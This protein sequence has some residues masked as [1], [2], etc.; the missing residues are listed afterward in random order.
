MENLDNFKNIDD[1]VVDDDSPQQNANEQISNN[2]VNPRNV[3]L[4]LAMGT[5]PLHD[6]GS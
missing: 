4:T 1:V 2:E 3:T 6:A 5:N